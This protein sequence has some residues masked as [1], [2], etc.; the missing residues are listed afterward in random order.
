ME[1]IIPLIEQ[2]ETLKDLNEGFGSMMGT[3]HYYSNVACYYTDGVR[4]LCNT[5]KCFWLLDL[6]SIYIMSIMKKTGEPVQVWVL[7]V[8]DN[9]ATLY[10]LGYPEPPD[11]ERDVVHFIRNIEYT[12][13]PNGK[14]MFKVGYNDP[15]P[16]ICLPVED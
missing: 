11:Y 8:K 3:S 5:L 13:L 4:D 16:I 2:D 1:T 14:I 10:C 7:Y 9:K 6:I 12:D 15:K